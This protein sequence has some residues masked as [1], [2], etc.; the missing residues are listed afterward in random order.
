[1]QDTG[2]E[3]GAGGEGGCLF[4]L[5]AEGFAD[6]HAFNLGVVSGFSLPSSHNTFGSPITVSGL[7]VYQ[8][9]FLLPL[10][11]SNSGGIH[12]TFEVCG[13]AALPHD[14]LVLDI[15]AEGGST[16]PGS[17]QRNVICIHAENIEAP[18]GSPNDAENRL[19]L[20]QDT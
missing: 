5:C 6:I 17:R 19:V 3:T 8:Q 9:Q 12:R 2:R 15:P 14:P 13:L 18:I 20:V 7:P 16:E 11:D 10:I 4:V 1:M